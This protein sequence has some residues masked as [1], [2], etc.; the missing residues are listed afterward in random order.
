[1]TF[2]SDILAM[3]QA[4][5]GAAGAGVTG[6]V[7]A[8]YSRFKKLEDVVAELRDFPNST[9]GGEVPTALVRLKA[10]ID[11]IAT[12]GASAVT[13]DIYGRRSLGSQA[14][15]EEEAARAKLV[16]GVMDEIRKLSDRLS[17]RIDGLEQEQMRLTRRVSKVED[18]FDESEREQVAT[19][20][21][22]KVDLGDIERALRKL[23]P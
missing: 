23:S 8:A 11:G 1:M 4:A 7:A 16:A 22:I 10:Y 13:T 5:G 17:D 6:V 20:R 3:L 21:K 9:H 19:W 15:L 2:S 18:E 14:N 12:L